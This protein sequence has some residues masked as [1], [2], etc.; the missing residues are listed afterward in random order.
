MQITLKTLFQIETQ[1]LFDHVAGHLLKQGVRSQKKE[2]MGPNADGE[3]STHL[4]CK[5]RSDGL[6]CAA[7]VCIAD[8]EYEEEVMEDIGIQSV[9]WQY[10]E[11]AELELPENWDNHPNVMLLVRLQT[12]HDRAEPAEW[13]WA[14]KLKAGK[15]GLTWNF[16][17]GHE[18]TTN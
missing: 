3:S 13:A 8:D 18:Q 2:V 5:Y 14:L 4:R 10:Y 1:V 9:I 17:D 12:L 15:N 16:G 7:G 6:M 11:R